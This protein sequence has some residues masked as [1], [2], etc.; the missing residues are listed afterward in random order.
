MCL[1]GS[2]LSILAGTCRLYTLVILRLGESP[3]VNAEP[4]TSVLFGFKDYWYRP[5]AVYGLDYPSA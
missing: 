2:S 3:V 1:R 5:L 4:E